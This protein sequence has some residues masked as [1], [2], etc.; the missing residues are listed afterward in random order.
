[1]KPVNYILN[2]CLL[3]ILWAC[4]DDV[5][6]PG[7]HEAGEAGME[8]V[9]LSLSVRPARVI[10]RLPDDGTA[11]TRVLDEAKEKAVDNIWVFQY[12]SKGNLIALP[13][14]YEPDDLDD[15]KI[16]LRPATSSKV[17]VLANLNDDK[18]FVSDS[19]ATEERF[20][21]LMFSFGKDDLH[22]EDGTN[23]L[24][25]GSATLDILPGHTNNFEIS[26]VRMLAKITFRIV[27]NEEANALKITRAEVK[28]IPAGFRA[29]APAAG[30]IYPQKLDSVVDYTI[31]SPASDV[32]YVW[33][34]P[35]NMQG[36]NKNTDPENKNRNAPANAL[37]LQL[38]VSSEAD[39]S[40][41]IYTIY[42]GM[43]TVDNFDV[44]RNHNYNVKLS[45]TSIKTD[46]RVVAAPANCYVM[47]HNAFIMFDPYTRTETGGGW[48][49]TD[50]VD[51]NNPDKALHDVDILWQ[52]G[53]GTHFPIGDNS[54]KD[55]VFFDETEQKVCVRSGGINGNAVIAAR[56][57]KGVIIWS[58]HIW[59]NNEAPAQLSHAV[60]YTTYSWNSSGINTGKRVPGYS[61][62]SCNLG[63]VSTSVGDIG[64]FGMYYQ[65]GRK[66]P[67]PQT[68]RTDGVTFYANAYPYVQRVYDSK[69]KLLPM[70]STAGTGELFRAV[71]VT[72]D[73]G[74]IEHSIQ[75][76]T[77]FMATVIPGLF[78]NGGE[79]SGQ[80][81]P[82]NGNTHD[83]AYYIN[84]GDWY[85][86]HNDKLWGGVPFDEATVNYNNVV[87]N[88]GATKKSLF[89]PCPAGWI[90]PRSDA[91]MGFTSTGLN[92]DTYTQQNYLNHGSEH[93][94][95]GMTFYMQAWRSGPTSFFPLC[96]WRT[97]DG[98]CFVVNGCGGYY[99]SAASYHNASSI[100]HIHPDLVNPY[101]YGYQYAR[102]SCAYPV[103]CVRE[104]M[105]E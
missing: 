16:M 24:M 91:W 32:D 61:F 66:D 102:R 51:K 38:Y 6:G 2:V 70:T 49:Y 74:N 100:F 105:D 12:D 42:P 83:P 4:A 86:G 84:D 57:A 22:D 82:G 50:Y 85:W 53:D 30:T 48:K 37:H 71:R 77:E 44:K 58:W 104:E 96:G 97:G 35:E 81:G 55:R 1:M 63:A 93:A 43:N 54:K 8:E 45:L 25:L 64:T 62:M 76:P 19:L 46:N 21:E 47:K 5:I 29:V 87:A 78:Q 101:D 95:H 60:K 92:T 79:S 90:L 34:M 69:A 67:F 7:T 10:G 65:W 56:N 27:K 68:A 39:G 28:N 26:L 80:P 41:Y 103:R 52:T 23:M 99:T 72:P 20:S 17:Y 3:C 89:D 18:G 15:V 73:T 75:N 88:N 59:V 11:S 13:R 14:Y 36:S 94:H 33:Y 40:N 9:S 98:S 31:K